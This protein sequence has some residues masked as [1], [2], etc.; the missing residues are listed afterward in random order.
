MEAHSRWLITEALR[1]MGWNQT[2]AAGLLKLQRTYLTK[3]M[4]QKKIPSRPA[5]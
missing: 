3:L 1:R 2:R 4:K 5:P